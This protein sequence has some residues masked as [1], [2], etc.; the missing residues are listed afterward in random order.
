MA[1]APHS[2]PNDSVSPSAR[3]RQ[4]LDC[5]LATWDHA[6][7]ERQPSD[8]AVGG[9]YYERSQPRMI[10]LLESSLEAAAAPPRVCTLPAALH[11]HYAHATNI[12][13]PMAKLQRLRLEASARDECHV[14]LKPYSCVSDNCSRAAEM[15][16]RAARRASPRFLAQTSHL[17]YRVTGAFP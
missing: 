14:A 12:A 3:T 15:L 9:A 8:P 2:S 16:A 11:E 13:S 6:A 17:P 4:L 10:H 7:F 1:A 5:A